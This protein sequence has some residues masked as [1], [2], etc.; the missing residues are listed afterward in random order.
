MRSWFAEQLSLFPEEPSRDTNSQTRNEPA[1][2]TT[3]SPLSL[4]GEPLEPPPPVYDAK[5]FR[6]AGSDLNEGTSQC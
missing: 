2:T 6:R 3:D 1:H 5:L 4:G